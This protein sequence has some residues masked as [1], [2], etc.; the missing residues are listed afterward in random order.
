V[1]A[2]FGE[3]NTIL[4]TISPSESKS[5]AVASRSVGFGGGFKLEDFVEEEEE[6]DSLALLDE[7][8]D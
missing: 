3:V 4:P 7:G 8:R 1:C 5:T 6:V 2:W